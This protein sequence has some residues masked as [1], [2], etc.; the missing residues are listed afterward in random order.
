MP[1]IPWRPRVILPGRNFRLPV[2]A[3]D[4]NIALTAE[5]F[6]TI[7]TRWCE[8]D[9]ARYY[10][11][12]S[13][14][15]QGDYTLIATHNGNTAET[16][17][18]VRTLDDMRQPHTYNGAQWP[19]RWPLGQ[20]YQPT[21]TRQTLQNDPRTE[22]LNEE[23]ITWWS[24]Q[25]DHVLWSQ[26]PP[27]ELPK[28]HFANCHQGCPNCGT[29]IF[30][31][32][33]FYPWERNHLPC[34]FKSQCPNCASIYPS[35]NLIKEDYISG[36]HADDGY[37]YF[38]AEGHIY[39]FAA[40]YHRDQCRAYHAGINA[41]TDS[42]RAT[43]LDE[44]RT[45][46]LGLMLLRYATEE[47]Y[48]AA[49][50]QFRY[51]PSK[52]VE[53]PWDW[54]QPDWAEETDPVAALQRK[55]TIRYS[56]DTPYLIESLA[57]AYDTAWPLLR[58]DTEL[59]ERARAFGLS[60]QGPEDTCLFI[61]EMLAALLQ[62]T[63]DRGASSNLPRESQGALI[64][65]RCLDRADARDAMDWVYDEGPDTLR[66]FSTNDFFPDGTPLEAT[67]G[68][69]AIHS[70]GLFDLE[71]H[72]RNLR[73][74]QPDA[75]PES[76]YPSLCNDARAARVPRA[77]CEITMIGKSYF[78]FGDGSAPGSAGIHEQGSIRLKDDLYHA[79]MNASVL[80]R[81]IAFTNDPHLAEIQSQ[82]NQHRALGP[83]ILD[84]VGIA[85][86]RTP[87]VP[88]RAAVGIAY[89][90][91]MH[92]RHR[93]LLDI[94]LF[95]FDRPF[96]T[97]LGYPQ[98]WASMSPWEAHWAT[99][100][101]V[102]ADLPP[103]EPTS[104]GRG[105]LVRALFTDGIQ[106]LDIEA[107]RWALDPSG[108]WRKV[109][110]TYRRLIALIETDGEGIA[111]LD[112]SRIT[113]GVEH[114][115]TCRGLEGIFQTD[116]ADF[117][118]QPGTVAGPNIPR[119]QTDNLPHP[120]HTALAYMDNVTT[121]Q[122]PPA[123]RGTW[124][125][126]IEP[127]VHLDLHQ[128]NTSSNTQLYNTRAAQAMGT[129]E[130]SNY[131]YHPVIW[132]RT[133]DNDT[134]CIDL[135]FEPHLDN[136]TIANTTAI[137]SNNPTAA[138]IHLTTAHGKQ[139]ALYWAPNASPDDKTQFENGVVLT[140]A[141]AVV[142]DGH[143]STMGATAFQN[144]EI[145]LTNPH[146]QQT[147]RIIALNRNTCTIDVE[148]LQNITPGDR[149]TINPDDRAHSYRIEAAEQLSAHIH[150]LTLDVTSILGRAKVVAIEDNKID[151]GFQIPAKSGNLHGTRLQTGDD[152][153]V[154]TNAHNSS[155]WPPG[156]I[157]TTITIDPNNNKLQNLS[158]GTW[159]Q[160]VDYVI[161]DHVLFEPLCRG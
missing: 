128:L 102:W 56:I 151:F 15:Q 6:E 133:P 84:G 159:V 104:A 143:I 134:T 30:K 63:L 118:P 155:T 34:D 66:V 80:E 47:L 129:P 142:A 93:D 17:I 110:I 156:K 5:H 94:Q 2:Q 1:S 11:L 4:D 161:G 64:L 45:R 36:E 131:L 127:A 21:K 107:H 33:G 14:Q 120:D 78:Q 86:L 147:G 79:P 16:T 146:A 51:G 88:E 95:A 138:G 23:T 92:H 12:R 108:G 122:A 157:R 117:K 28:A 7:A 19:R 77:L 140:G 29:A 41:L 89:G 55:G 83:T 136:P 38:D 141:L 70:D 116:N 48:L 96:L 132:R 58:E 98:S 153:A 82:K 26:L 54:G 112:L 37:G 52:G 43:Y 50:P 85:I 121:A 152:W 8:R 148:G 60:L 75:Y 42:L 20:N 44:E 74:Q 13:P 115:R 139:I 87:E 9:T 53:E 124:Q 158:P 113:G 111:L 71:Y 137:P 150:R 31:Y 25:P 72:L 73:N 22:R 69:N 109:D 106:V 135:V 105:R 101:T 68:Y 145:T 40:T 65:L 59:V 18:Q 81:A 130:E 27:A 57:L 97:D 24:S 76:L 119:A 67:G 46:K 99:H 154:I 149:I 160:V 35:N 3:T 32:S 125:S 103:G 39:L 144:A 49:V 90:D 10:Y 123:F 62:V 126:Q 100:N 114:W 61:E 91:T